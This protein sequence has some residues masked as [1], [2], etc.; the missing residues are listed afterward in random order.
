M[1]S[2]KVGERSM[3]SYLFLFIT[4]DIHTSSN[5]IFSILS[6]YYTWDY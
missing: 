2:L 6:D 3:Y 5:Q 1:C 4:T